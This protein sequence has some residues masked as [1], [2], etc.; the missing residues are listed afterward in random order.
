[1][2]QF[3]LGRLHRF[4][5]GCQLGALFLQLFGLLAELGRP[6][7]EDCPTVLNRLK[8][9]EAVLKRLRDCRT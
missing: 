1:M 7:G 4:L 9:P 6:R 3:A 8:L 2:I 5:A